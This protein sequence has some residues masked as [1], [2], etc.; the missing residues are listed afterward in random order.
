MPLPTVHP[1]A[2]STGPRR[3]A[4]R[5]AA[6]LALAGLLLVAGAGCSSDPGD[7]TAASGATT[8]APGDPDGGATTTTPADPS[9]PGDGTTTAPTVEAVGTYAVGSHEETLVDDTRTTQAHGGEAEKPDRTLPVLVLYPTDGGTAPDPEADIVVDAPPAPGPWPL[10]VFSHGLSGNGPAYTTTLRVWASAGYVVVAP[11]YPLANDET[12]GGSTPSDIPEQTADVAFVIDWA[13][14]ASSADDGP[15]AGL[16]DGERVGLAGHS[17]GAITSVAVG[18]NPCC[19]DPRVG[20]VAE[21]AGGYATD[22]GQG[23]GE[24][25]ADGPPLLIVHGDADDTVPYDRAEDAF[26]RIDAPRTLV[27]LIGG[28]H[29][30]PYV[31]G[32]A[33]P[34]TTVVTLSALAFFDQHLKDDPDGADRL[35]AVVDDAGPTVATREDAPA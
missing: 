6:A 28:A 9:T 1:P 5:R 29:T 25:V 18:Y 13:R 23:G 27:T 17:L 19:Q 20:A 10:V 16:I 26:A 7:G 15:L 4:P 21:W 24:P 31:Q 32:L 3:P 33:H 35:A 11:T 2:A 30:P 14:Q 8:T 34:D 22:L 12:P